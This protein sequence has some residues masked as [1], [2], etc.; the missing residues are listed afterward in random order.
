MRRLPSLSGV[1]AFVAVARTGSVKVAAEELSLSSPALSRRIQSLERFV[2][3][4][5]FT[6]GHQSM[7]INADGERLMALVAP[8]L[9]QLSDAIESMSS[10]SGDLMRLRL[11]VLPLFAAQRLI[12]RLPEL[13]EKHRALHIDIDTA[14]HA[15]A[16]LGDGIDAAIVL[17]HDTDPAVYAR[18]LDRNMVFAIASTHY[19]TGPGA[20]VRPEQLRDL[21]VLIHRDMPETFDAWRKAIGNPTLEPAAIDQYDS[22]QLMLDA[23]AQGLGVAFMHESHLSDAHDS[24]LVRLFDIPV[25]SP[26][27]Y[28]FVCRPRALE[29]RPVRL[30]HDWLVEA[31]AG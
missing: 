11:G 1:E 12:P 27:S 26:Y 16:R 9:D 15:A 31:M 10:A 23:A 24:R 2:A 7:R 19:R 28:W 20:I 14:P 25:E 21:T 29:L 13:R 22:G 30:F 4:P 3:R 6:R 8:A 18:R 17:A 5:L